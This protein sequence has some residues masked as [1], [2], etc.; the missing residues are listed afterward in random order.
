MSRYFFCWILLIPTCNSF[1]LK[2]Y[3][4]RKF[5]H[6]ITLHTVRNTL[7]PR[8]LANRSWIISAYYVDSTAQYYRMR[9]AVRARC[10]VLLKYVGYISQATLCLVTCLARQQF[11][12]CTGNE[13]L[14][15]TCPV[16][17]ATDMNYASG[18]WSIGI[19]GQEFRTAPLSGWIKAN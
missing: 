16:H 6:L 3:F 19:G 5:R 4:L 14:A 11:S 12:A 10:N 1:D 8:R 17:T 13:I 15:R 7:V 2:V 18:L 9:L